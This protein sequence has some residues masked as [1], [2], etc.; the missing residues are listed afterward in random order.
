MVWYAVSPPGS[1]SSC[2]ESVMTHID[3]QANSGF[4]TVCIPQLEGG[5]G[6]KQS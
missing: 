6:D 3:R 5:G 1:I 2:I 4:N